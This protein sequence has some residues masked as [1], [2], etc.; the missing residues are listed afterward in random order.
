MGGGEVGA[1]PKGGRRNMILSGLLKMVIQ[2]SKDSFAWPGS[3]RSCLLA[4]L[5]YVPEKLLHA[6]VL[7]LT[8]MPVN[9]LFW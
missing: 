1:I 4:H 6:E 5:Q 9:D 7:T 3:I 2:H 8:Q